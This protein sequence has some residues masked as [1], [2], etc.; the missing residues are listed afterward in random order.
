MTNNQPNNEERPTMTITNDEW[1]LCLIL[2]TRKGVLKVALKEADAV[3]R[4][5]VAILDNI[6]NNTGSS[7]MENDVID[8]ESGA[9]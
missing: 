3:E 4:S 1:H 7:G 9:V 5:E 6:D 8:G 2:L